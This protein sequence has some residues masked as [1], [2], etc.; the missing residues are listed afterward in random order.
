M[1]KLTQG[2]FD[3]GDT[4]TIE[5][6]KSREEKIQEYRDAH[7]KEYKA[8]CHDASCTCTPTRAQALIM[9][10]FEHPQID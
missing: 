6:P 10:A 3:M 1:N 9:E 8:A 4:T 5:K 7:L 2:E